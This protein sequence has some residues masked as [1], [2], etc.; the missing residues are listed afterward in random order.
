VASLVFVSFDYDHDDDLKTL[1]INQ[2][3]FPD[4]PFEVS[5]WSIKIASP[6]WRVE[7]RR[8]IR[9]VDRVVVICGQYTNSASG[10]AAEVSIAQEESISYFLLWGRNGKTCVKPTSA[11]ASDT[12][13]E[14]TWPNLKK[15]IG[16]AR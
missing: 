16:G 14:W 10:V 6:N 13:Y 9:A 8:R 3:R 1:L 2:A 5:D 11:K 15:L 4:S 7:A 12:I